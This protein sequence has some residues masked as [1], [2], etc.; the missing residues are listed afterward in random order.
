MID[1]K[2][3]K[4][5]VHISI[6]D[7]SKSLINLTNYQYQSVFELYLFKYLRILHIIFGAKFTLYVFV[8]D[9][10]WSIENLPKKYAIELH[11]ESTWLKFACHGIS[12]QSNE[13]DEIL[14][15]KAIQSVNNAFAVDNVAK[16]IRLHYF[17]YPKEYI[18]VLNC[19]KVNTILIRN[20]VCEYDETW[21]GCVWETSMQLE[22]STNIINRI[23][24][25][26]NMSQPLVI[27]T[28]EWSLTRKNKIRLALTIALLSFLRFK[29]ICE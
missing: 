4:K 20:A 10:E 18:K 17:T 7:V 27:F 19:N 15:F 3:K 24:K 22:K 2:C 11:K 9:G 16:I 14:F 12:P 5:Y 1:R 29:Y 23:F 6:D 25:C 8:K 13:I 26:R 28:H 21:K